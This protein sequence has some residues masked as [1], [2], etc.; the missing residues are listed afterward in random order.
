MEC[1]ICDLSVTCSGPG[2]VRIGCDACRADGWWVTRKSLAYFERGPL[3]DVQRDA[4]R[5]LIKKGVGSE[6]RPV[7]HH[8]IESL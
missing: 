6:D 3:N 1:P 7:N 5:S 2:S 4:L 8:A